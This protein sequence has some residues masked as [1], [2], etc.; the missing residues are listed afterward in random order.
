MIAPATRYLKTPLP[1]GMPTFPAAR[2]RK[3]LPATC[4]PACRFAFHWPL[5]LPRRLSPRF[6]RRFSRRLPI[7]PSA[8]RLF[9]LHTVRAAFSERPSRRSR[10][11]VTVRLGSRLPTAHAYVC[12]LRLLH[13]LVPSYR[14]AV[15]ISS[16]RPFR[17]VVRIWR[18]LD[19]LV[20]WLREGRGRASL[21]CP[22]GA[23]RH[24]SRWC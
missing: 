5:R 23:G 10:D 20:A 19:R 6:P 24:G 18:R 8:C 13:R 2:Y 17:L 22:F 11:V 14:L 9:R 4:L 3:A 1:D 15:V 16:L 12:R 7:A 21:T